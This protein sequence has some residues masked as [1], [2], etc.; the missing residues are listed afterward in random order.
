MSHVL[1]IDDSKNTRESVK[2]MLESAGFDVAVAV[3]GEDGVT[4]LRQKRC[5]L[6]ISDIVMPRKDGLQTIHEIRELAPDIPIVAIGA[7]EEFGATRT[8]GKPLSRDNLLEVIR[9]SI[10]ETAK[11]RFLMSVRRH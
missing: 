9:D 1:L 4:Q 6:V 8:N 2:A 10:V 3:D 7:V 5:D 11:A